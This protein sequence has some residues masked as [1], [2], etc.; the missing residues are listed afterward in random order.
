MGSHEGVLH[1]PLEFERDPVDFVPQHPLPRF[2]H[3]PVN[4]RQDVLVDAQVRVSVHELDDPHLLQSPLDV[5][6]G[7][8]SFLHDVLQGKT[9][10]F[11]QSDV[12]DQP[13]RPPRQV[14]FTTQVRQGFFRGPHFLLDDAEII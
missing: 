14:S 11:V 6:F 1:L 10:M 8:G 9:F 4:G 7:H 5:L 2:P 12:V 3:L 13:L